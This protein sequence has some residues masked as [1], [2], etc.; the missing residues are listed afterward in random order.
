MATAILMPAFNE[1]VCIE[2]TVREWLPVLRATASPFT[3][4]VLNDGSKDGTLAILRKLAAEIPELEVVDKPNT[5]HGQTCLTGYRLARERGAEWVLQIDSDGQCD[6]SFFPLLWAERSQHA[7]I[8]GYRRTR[9]DGAARTV[10]SRVVSVA[11]LIGSH[12]WVR[13]AN[14]PY[15]LMR[16]DTLTS[17]D[18][19]PSDFHLA[20]VAMAALQE[21]DFGIHWI[22]IHF[23]N[24]AGGTASVK[25]RA[26]ARHG[27][28]LYLQL[29]K[30]RRR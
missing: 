1:E 29:R 17:A 13:D 6:P 8:Y 10:I 15:R 12:S 7:V 21:R 3:F 26:F 25:P 20:N 22:D 30:N 14:V 28:K 24:R 4:C 27:W 18:Q 2:P 5:G 19:I 9:A 16:R 11:T 23:R